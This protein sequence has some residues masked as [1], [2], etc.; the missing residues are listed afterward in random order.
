MINNKM[1]THLVNIFF[2][3]PKGNFSFC[4]LITETIENGKAV[5]YLNNLFKKAFGFEMPL[6]TKITII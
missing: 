5:V 1:K 6:Q 2:E 4:G 3:T